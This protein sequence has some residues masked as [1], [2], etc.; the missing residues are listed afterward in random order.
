MLIA[1]NE[2]IFFPRV[3]VSLYFLGNFFL[4]NS[5]D[6]CSCSLHRVFL[7][8][9]SCEIFKWLLI[10][11]ISDLQWVCTDQCALRRD[12]AFKWRHCNACGVAR[13]L[14]HLIVP[15]IP[16]S[17]CSNV[18]V[19]KSFACKHMA[20][21]YCEIFFNRFKVKH[22]N[23][24]EDTDN[25]LHKVTNVAQNAQLTK[26]N[27]LNIYIY[28]SIYTYIYHILMFQH[29]FYKLYKHLLEKIGCKI[30]PYF[31]NR[32]WHLSTYDNVKCLK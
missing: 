23:F 10:A 2:W 9:T 16:L 25:N 6:N 12:N 26:L 8:E 18:K 14:F 29:F 31:Y 21:K 7:H 17:L 11:V 28:A 19:M 15:F 1:H 24:Q 32:A 3:K 13:S 5:F 4:L 27:I 30:I 22:R 20:G